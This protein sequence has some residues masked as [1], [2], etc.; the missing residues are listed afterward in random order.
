MK[1]AYSFDRDD[2]SLKESYG[3][4]FNAYKK[5]F[6]RLEIDYKIVNASVGAMGGEL[7]EEF[8]AITDRGEDIVV[9]CDKCGL[10]TNEEICECN[11]EIEVSK[12][13]KKKKE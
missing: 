9:L 3:K 2:E 4:M 10:S 5:I 7:S 12:V 1:D 6:D 8:Q 13:R 11:G